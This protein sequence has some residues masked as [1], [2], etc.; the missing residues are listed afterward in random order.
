MA[1]QDQQSVWSA[2]LHIQSLAWHSGLRIQHCHSCDIG[3][4]CDSNLIVG[5]KLDASIFNLCL[6]NR[7]KTY[8]WP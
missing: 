5:R 2:R 1:Q 3:H 6:R 8:I 4:K 7:D